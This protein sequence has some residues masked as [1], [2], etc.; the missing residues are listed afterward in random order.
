MSPFRSIA[1]A[2]ALIAA[3]AGGA[4]TALR[5]DVDAPPAAQVQAQPE[6]RTGVLAMTRPIYRDLSS[7]TLINRRVGVR[8]GATGVAREASP[9]DAL[10]RASEQRRARGL[11]VLRADRRLQRAAQRHANWMA[12]NGVMA[13]VGEG[14]KRFTHRIAQTGYRFCFGAENVAFGQRSPA[15]VV[16]AWMRSPP[17]RRALLD[18]RAVDAA[19]AKATDAR[20]Q[21]YWA[22]LLGQPC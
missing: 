20:G 19:V 17:H 13:H 18:P 15:S 5:A 8:G 14:G 3:I 22:M 2:G 21:V 9:G 4:P 12:R 16:A 6:G 10:A 7:V 11:G 1:L